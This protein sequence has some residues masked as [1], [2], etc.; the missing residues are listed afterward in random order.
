MGIK[1]ISDTEWE[2][3][4]GRGGTNDYED[5]EFVP[6]GIEIAGGI[7]TWEE[8]GKARELLSPLSTTS[9]VNLTENKDKRCQ[10]DHNRWLTDTSFKAHS[11]PKKL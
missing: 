3:I 1:K 7:I 8:V 6:E 4:H 5:I 11:L 9:Q 10:Q 2:L